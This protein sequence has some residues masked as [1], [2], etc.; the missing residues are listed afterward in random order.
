MRSFELKMHR[1]HFR[2]YCQCLLHAV[3]LCTRVRV[4]YYRVHIQR[5]RETYSTT[6][7]RSADQLPSL[8]DRLIDQPLFWTSVI[9]MVIACVSMIAIIVL[10]ITRTK[11]PRRA[12]LV[13]SRAL[14]CNQS[15]TSGDTEDRKLYHHGD[16]PDDDCSRLNDSH[17]CGE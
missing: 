2:P 8:M 5:A 7:G 6:S 15:A 3:I 9:S 4:E 13:L 12:Y 14:N 10:C 1:I 17:E 11:R 16:D